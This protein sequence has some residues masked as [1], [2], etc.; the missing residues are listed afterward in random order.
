MLDFFLILFLGKTEALTSTPIALGKVSVEIRPAKPIAAITTGAQ[1]L[2]DISSLIPNS[3]LMQ[4]RTASRQVFPEGC[5]RG[6]LKND[7]GKSVEIQSNGI[8][9]MPG[10][11]DLIVAS[12]IGV[13]K[14]TPFSSLVIS[15]CREIP[16]A[17]LR[18]QN[19]SK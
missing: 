7:D 12:P 15:S 10:S 3:D 19:Y 9:W 14:D 8:S 6:T 17:I 18:W 13:P 2:L 4:A 11:V 16:N 1:I 5:I